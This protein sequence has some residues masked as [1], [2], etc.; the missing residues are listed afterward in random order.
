M[1]SDVLVSGGTAGAFTAAGASVYTLVVTPTADVPSGLITV[2]VSAGAAIDAA[3]ASSPAASA[4]QAYDTLAPALVVS[5][6]PTGTAAG[7]VTFTFA[8]SEPV[9]GFAASD[10]VVT[11]GAAGP[12]TGTGSTYTMV[13]TPPAGG[14]GTMTVDVPAGAATDAAGQ[15]SSGAA[16]IVVVPYDTRPL[17]VA[18]TDN[19]PGA[20]ASGPIV[21]TFAWSKPVIG[22]T[23]SD[24]VVS[25]G[26]AGQFA[27]VTASTYTLLVFPLPGTSGTVSVSIPPGVAFDASGIF[28]AA[29]ASASQSYNTDVSPPMA[30]ISSSVPGIANGPVAISISWSEPVVGFTLPDV[31]VS[32][33]SGGTIGSFTGS[34]STYSLMFTPS[35]GQAGVL[36]L[37]I[38]PG[39]VM[40]AAGN[41]NQAAP[42]FAQ[43]YDRP[44]P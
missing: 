4:T 32:G 29:L 3:G 27:Q 24:V 33:L 28:N 15:P 20:T 25:G 19:V 8:F 37:T 16:A 17:I 10:I 6:N 41:A 13:V 44:A 34:G 36:T 22:F 21:F 43:S 30:V 42:V 35:A 1:A 11:G 31:A 7:P 2:Q 26:T 12:L 5:A 9:S 40:D 23:Q 38:G 39:A 18:I 14:V